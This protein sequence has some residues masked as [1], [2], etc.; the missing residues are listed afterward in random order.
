MPSGKLDTYVEVDGFEY[1]NVTVYYDESPAEPDVNWA[2]G[3][4]ITSIMYQEQDLLSSLPPGELALFSERVQEEVYQ[5]EDDDGGWEPPEP[6]EAQEWYD[7]DPD[8]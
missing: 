5:Y 1:R 8:C 6:D 4:E 2:G 3:F 7:Y